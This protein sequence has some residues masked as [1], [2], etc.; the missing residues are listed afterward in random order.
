MYGSSPIES[1]AEYMIEAGVKC[2]VASKS[3]VSDERAAHVMRKFYSYLLKGYTIL[4]AAQ[5]AFGREE[6]AAQGAVVFPWV[7]IGKNQRL[8]PVEKK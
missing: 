4:E 5:Y 1:I 2:V 7:I 8:W 3:I 6:R